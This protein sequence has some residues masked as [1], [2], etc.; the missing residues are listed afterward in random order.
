MAD[1]DRNDDMDK[2]LYKVL[3]WSIDQLDVA[4]KTAFNDVV[5]FYAPQEIPWDF[6]E[7]AL[8]ETGRFEVRKL[9]ALVLQFRE[10]WMN[11]MQNV[12]T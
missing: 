6:V 9:G 7:Y 8:D 3:R 11:K 10:L 2:Q 12:R 4:Y 1:G 5:W